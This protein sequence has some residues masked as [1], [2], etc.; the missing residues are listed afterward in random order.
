[1]FQ[2]A[3]PSVYQS[4]R[5]FITYGTMGHIDPKQTSRRSKPWTTIASQDFVHKVAPPSQTA[6]LSRGPANFVGAKVD[7]I[8]PQQ[9]HAALRDKLLQDQRLP[10][11]SRVTMALGQVL[12]GSFFTEYVKNGMLL[13]PDPTVVTSAD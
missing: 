11:Y 4:S 1:M 5:C 2:Q 3:S 12:Q 7:L 9:C 8:V 6:H 13:W 10:H